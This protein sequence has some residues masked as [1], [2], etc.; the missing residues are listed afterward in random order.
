MQIIVYTGCEDAAQ[1]FLDI[2]CPAAVFD[3]DGESAITMMIEKMPLIAQSAL[4]QF[5]IVDK[6]TGKKQY[7]L[8]ALH[9]VESEMNQGKSVLEVSQ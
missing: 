7:F 3:R 4:S 5:M 9:S 2:G 1:Y 8:G 6:I